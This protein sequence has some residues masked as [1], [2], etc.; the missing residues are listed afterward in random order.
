MPQVRLALSKVPLVAR[1]AR[2]KWGTHR[3]CD[4]ELVMEGSVMENL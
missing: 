4:G 2:E 3:T 1:R